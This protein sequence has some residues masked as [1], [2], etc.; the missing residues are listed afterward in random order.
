MTLPPVFATSADPGILQPDSLLLADDLALDLVLQAWIVALTGL[1]GNLVRPRWQPAPPA[2]PD[3]SVNWCAIGV[4]HTTPDANEAMTHVPSA[5]GTLSGP[6]GQD[7]I[8]SDPYN[9]ALDAVLA[10][11]GLGVSTMQRHE[12]IEALAT[13]YGPMAGGFAGLLRD[14]SRIGQNRD[15]LTDAGIQF[16]GT[17]PLMVVPDLINAIWVRR[18]DLSLTLRRQIARTYPIR[19]LL[20]A[21]TSLINDPT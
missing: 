7:L 21:P 12:E 11:P 15:G 18:V 4:M 20:A 19:T 13:F 14:N 17:G 1:P 16:V 3:Q 8:G 10:D 9:P 6:D 2:M 5:I